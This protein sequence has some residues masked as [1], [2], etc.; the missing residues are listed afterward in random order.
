MALLGG[1]FGLA[2]LLI[3]LFW[4]WEFKAADG[5]SDFIY[6]LTTPLY[7]LTFGLS[8]LSI[9]IGAVLYQKRF[10]PEEISIQERHDGASREIDRKTVVANLTDAF[11]G[12][13]I[14]RRKLIGLSFGVGMGAFGLG[15]LVAFAGGLIK[16]PWKPV[17]PT[18][19]GKK[20]VLWTSGW[21]PATRA[22]RSIWRAPPARRTDHRSS[23]CARRI[24]TPVEW[25]PFSLAGV[26]RRRHHRRITP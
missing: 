23:K 7:G 26:R 20:A 12:S 25:R 2:L 3:F 11:E 16:N 13:T 1:V 10:I 9:A 19:E 15:T 8:I 24:W 22:R 4:P 6:S 14:R 21:T 5:E 18:A 17:V